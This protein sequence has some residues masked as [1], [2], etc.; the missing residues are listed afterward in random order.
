[1]LFFWIGCN[2]LLCWYSGGT[3]ID[4]TSEV[5]VVSVELGSWS[6]SWEL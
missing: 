1:M 5:V 6:E 2:L 4:E 3:G